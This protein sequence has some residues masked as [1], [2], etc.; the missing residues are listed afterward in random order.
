MTTVDG[1]DS[2]S[3]CT[4]GKLFTFSEMQQMCWFSR[5][6]GINCCEE[7]LFMVI[8]LGPAPSKPVYYQSDRYSEGLAGTQP[9]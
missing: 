3:S 2:S 8:A 4:L 5:D 1:G 6:T 7:H 9:V